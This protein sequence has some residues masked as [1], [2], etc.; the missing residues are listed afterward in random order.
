MVDQTLFFTCLNSLGARRLCPFCFQL[1]PFEQTGD[2]HTITRCGDQRGNTLATSATRA[3]RAVQQGFSVCRRFSVDNQL[4]SR[5][6]DTTCSNVCRNADLCT[7]VAHRLKRVCPFGLGQFARERYNLETTVRQAGRQT[8]H[9]CA[10]VRKDDGVIGVMEQKRVDDRVFSIMRCTVE[11]LI[12]N[13][14]VLLFF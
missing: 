2:F 1:R 7:T 12:R 8:G 13:V 6:V 11:N 4:K 10:R 14:R 9:G 3:A 5:K